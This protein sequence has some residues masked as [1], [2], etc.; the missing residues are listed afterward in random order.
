MILTVT[1]NPAVDEEYVVPEFRPGGWF[2]ASNVN[3]SPG[4]K[5]IN[6]SILLK[7]M[8]F[9]SVA[10]G[11]L[12]G[13]NGEY[14]RDTLSKLRIATSFVHVRGE[15]RTNT[16]V[17]D[18]IG[19]LETGIA[20]SG[21][22]VP[23]EALGRFLRAYERM[24]GRCSSVMLGGSL[25]PGVPQDIYRELVHMASVR[26]LEVFVDASGGAL[27]AAVDGGPKVVKVDHRFVSMMMDVPLSSLDNL[28]SVASR[29]HDQGVP[30]VITSY[31]GYGDMFSTPRG[32]FVGEVPRRGVVSLF[33]A[34]DAL[35]AGLILAFE[36]GMDEEE[37]IR[38]AMACA[39]EDSLHLEKGVSSR[40]A[41]ESHLDQIKLTRVG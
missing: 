22:Y 7:Q 3:R 15:T 13:Y 8:G 11:F 21:P 14:I 10:M 24:L 40:S 12:A 32:T 41:V 29:F 34:G 17:V 39:M 30:W 38:F 25:P 18:E 31:R 6:V 16:Y 33:G 36:E 9:D 2:R 37:A 5:G 27:L 20:E 26:G 4:G 28:K 19:K 35:M 1:L 23:E